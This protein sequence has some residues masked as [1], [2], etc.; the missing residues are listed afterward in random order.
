MQRP[1]SISS[2]ADDTTSTS[3]SSAWSTAAHSRRSSGSGASATPINIKGPKGKFLLQDDGRR[4]LFVATGHRAG[5][6][7]EHDRR[8]CAIGGRQRD[9]W[10]AP[11]GEL[12][13]RPRLAGGA[14]DLAA[15]R[16]TAA[17]RSATRRRSRARS[18]APDWQGL[19]GR[20]EAMLDA[21]LDANALTA[22]EHHH[23]PVRQPRHDQ[24]G[25]GDRGGRGFA[26]EQVRKELYWP[27]GREH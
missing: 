3:S 5:A 27:K 16:P 1:M 24:R 25:R 13:A 11:R 18:R 19:T 17:S 14:H 9:I 6:V 21:Q 2:S 4:C 12:R 7:H 26:P 15:P 8:R 20:A 22:G 10:T 23:L